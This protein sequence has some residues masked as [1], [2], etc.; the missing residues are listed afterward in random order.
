MA[1]PLPH[2]CF[3][4]PQHRSW[5]PRGSDEL[6]EGFEHLSYESFAGPIPHRNRTSRTAHSQQLARHDVRSRSEHGSDQTRDDVEAGVFK[7][8]RF[9]I[10]FYESSVQSLRLGTRL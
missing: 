5:H 1:Q 7:W 10:A 8:E 2:H 6:G 9:G 3:I 4:A